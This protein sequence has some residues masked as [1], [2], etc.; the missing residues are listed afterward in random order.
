MRRLIPAV[1]VSSALSAGAEGLS[2]NR[3]IRPILSD[4]C[5]AC[6]GM[7]AKKREAK[8]RL[9]LPDAAFAQNKEGKSAI[10]PGKPAESLAW[11]RIT[12][13]DQDDVMPPPDSHK[14]LSPEEKETIRKWIEQGAPYQKHW[15]FEPA[16]KPALPDGAGAAGIDSFLSARLKQDGLALSPEADRETLIRRVSMALT[17]L[18][19]AVAEVDAFLNDKADGAYERMVDR[20]FASPHYGEEM[21][22]YWLDVARYADTHGM[23]LDNE[24]QMWAYR[25]WVVSAFNRNL[26]FDEF[27]IDQLAGDLLP[28][29]TQDQIVATGFNRCNVTSGEGGSIDAEYIF[30]YAVDRASTT[31]QA[32]LGLTAGCAVCH[33]HKYDPISAKEFYSLYAFFHS[34]ADP[35]MDG[36]A[37][38]TQPVAKVKPGG[39]D[40]KVKGLDDRMAAV[41]KRMAEKAATVA[42][43]DPA[44]QNPKPPVTKLEQ[45]WF[46]DAFPQGA[47]VGASGHP[48]TFV[49]KPV[50]SGKKALKRGGPAMAQDYYDSGAAAFVVPQDGK[51]FVSVYPDPAD[52]PKEVMIQF[53]SSDWKHRAVWGE[54]IIE[55]GTKNTTERFKAGTLPPAGRWTR[56]EVDAAKMGLAP[57]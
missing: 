34:S 1:L 41:R 27:T 31:A 10:V 24:R 22:R 17:G 33:D 57:G 28:N 23:H 16:V 35:A 47:Q 29:A 32:W 2:F 37:L 51:F 15:A 46:D 40:A 53:N 30:R 44:E 13:A 26:G 3:D 38:L 19:P 39:Y 36:N 55:F 42:Y 49:D 9:D 20:Y 54:D 14:K 6:H 25:D 12:T 43:Q 4:K 21:A 5:F 48:T 18:P 56:L 50:A 11:Q 8:L 7:D 45:V 52:L